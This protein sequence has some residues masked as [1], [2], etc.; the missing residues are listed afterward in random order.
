MKIFAVLSWFPCFTI[1][2]DT[3]KFI[4]NAV[5]A[6]RTSVVDRTLVM[7]SV[8]L[9]VTFRVRARDIVKLKLMDQG[10][11]TVSIRVD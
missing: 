3:G 7:V 8:S 1:I 9:R 4:E 11:V 10:D 6:G 5:V 2:G